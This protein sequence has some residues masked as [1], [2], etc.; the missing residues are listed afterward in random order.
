MIAPVPIE[1]KSEDG[2]DQSYTA[3]RHPSSKRPPKNF[4]KANRYALREQQRM[5]KNAEIEDKQMEEKKKKKIEQRKQQRFGNIKSRVCPGSLPT[6][7]SQAQYAAPQSCPLHVES[8]N[9]AKNNHEFHIAFG[10]KVPSSRS[11]VRVNTNERQSGDEKIF[12]RHKSFGKTPAYITNRRAKIEREEYERMLAQQNAPPAPGL[13]LM[14][15]FERLE[16]LRILEENEKTQREKL[17]SIPF[18]MNGHRAARIREAIEF[19][20]KEIEDAKKIFSKDRV[21]VA[22][23]DT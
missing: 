15:E 23:S 7:R 5:N 11:S 6:N 1:V 4:V 8:D 16:T 17:R 19:H 13:V 10:R 3:T 2:S 20:L 9:D 12:V 18:A 22:Q 21:F 14:D